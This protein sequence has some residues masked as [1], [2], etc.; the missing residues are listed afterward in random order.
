M[1]A[2]S[3]WLDEKRSPW[4]MNNASAS[5]KSPWRLV[6]TKEKKTRKEKANAY[7]STR[8]SNT[9]S[10]ENRARCCLIANKSQRGYPHSN[11][12]DNVVCW[13]RRERA[14]VIRWRRCG[15][16]MGN[17]RRKPEDPRDSRGRGRTNILLLVAA[18][19][20]YE[21]IKARTITK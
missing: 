5:C 20:I 9:K 15:D 13:E 6:R 19:A 10:S 7:R 11:H 16:E 1:T 2:F 8:G 4:R 14:S 3:S 12:C 21:R 18:R 17:E